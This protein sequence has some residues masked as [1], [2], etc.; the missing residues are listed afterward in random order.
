MAIH[1]TRDDALRC[2]EFKY[3]P[4]KFLP[5]I[6]LKLSAQ[7]RG[8]N[9]SGENIRWPTVRCCP[10]PATAYFIKFFIRFNLQGTKEIRVLA[11]AAPDATPF[12]SE[13]CN[14]RDEIYLISS[15]RV[16]GRRTE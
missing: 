7:K 6:L 4:L 1:L 2:P 10:A 11:A 14:Y 5:D 3:A 16:V 12:H 13:Q 15:G 8:Q 9:S